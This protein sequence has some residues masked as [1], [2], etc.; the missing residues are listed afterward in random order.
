MY[1]SAMTIS[2]TIYFALLVTVFFLTK[3]LTQNIQKCQLLQ[4]IFLLKVLKG[5]PLFLALNAQGFKTR[6]SLQWH[7]FYLFRIRRGSIVTIMYIIFIIIKFVF[8]SKHW[9][10]QRT[11]CPCTRFGKNFIIPGQGEFDRWHPG[12]GRE[13][14]LT[15]FTVYIERAWMSQNLCLKGQ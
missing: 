5:R 14:W 15:F 6:I 13:K 10:I 11:L 7:S 12:W 1:W 2:Q 8:I 9:K 3:K 4:A